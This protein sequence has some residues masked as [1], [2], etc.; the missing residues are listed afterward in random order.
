MHLNHR[1]QQ[2]T[3]LDFLLFLNYPLGSEITAKND[4]FSEFCAIVSNAG[5]ANTEIPD[6]RI[7]VKMKNMGHAS[8]SDFLLFLKK[9]IRNEIEASSHA[10]C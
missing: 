10:M 1:M 7:W 8:G 2:A 6:G 3:G 9:S 4:C 5:T